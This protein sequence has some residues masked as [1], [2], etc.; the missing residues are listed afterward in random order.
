MLFAQ[1]NTKEMFMFKDYFD[2]YDDDDDD[3]YDDGFGDYDDYD[4]YDDDDDDEDYDDDADDGDDRGGNKSDKG[5]DNDESGYGDDTGDGFGED[6]QPKDEDPFDNS[7]DEDK[8]SKD[9]NNEDKSD[10]KSKEK[11]VEVT[12]KGKSGGKGKA[13]LEM[14]AKKNATRWGAFLGIPLGIRPV[15]VCPACH[16]RTVY[17]S[18]TAIDLILFK[19]IFSLV[20]SPVNV[21]FCMNGKKNCRYSFE[22]GLCW[23]SNGAFQ[24]G[25]LPVPYPLKLFRFNK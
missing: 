16:C 15:G 24:P 11:D 5:A 2:P 25:L 17:E 6:E 14:Q 9:K 19:A 1:I 12:G 22:R 8:N 21:Y 3:G 20:T 23:I 13:R 7:Q 10:K 18:K 4:D